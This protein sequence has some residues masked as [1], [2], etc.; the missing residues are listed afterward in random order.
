MITS[1]TNYNNTSNCGYKD[2][3]RKRKKIRRTILMAVKTIPLITCKITHHHYLTFSRSA[4]SSWKG[5]III[6]FVHNS[7][8][9]T[10]NL[11]FNATLNT[12]ITLLD[13]AIIVCNTICGNRGSIRDCFR[14]NINFYSSYNYRNWIQSKIGTKVCMRICMRKKKKEEFNTLLLPSYFQYIHLGFHHIIS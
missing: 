7:Q 14:L 1:I 11:I 5:S 8:T 2:C 4:I 10:N 3:M 12:I 13:S 6:V 9:T